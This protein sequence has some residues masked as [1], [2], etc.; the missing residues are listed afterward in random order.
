MSN[1]AGKVQETDQPQAVPSRTD[2]RC[3]DHGGTGWRSECWICNMQNP[4]LPPL[5]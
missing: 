5:I 3:K 1:E 4:E 2:D